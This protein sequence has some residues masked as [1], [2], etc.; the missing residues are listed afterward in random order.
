MQVVQSFKDVPHKHQLVMDLTTLHNQIRSFSSLFEHYYEDPF[1]V[2]TNGEISSS[3]IPTSTNCVISFVG[4]NVTIHDK[5]LIC[6]FV[7]I[8]RERLRAKWHCNQCRVH[9]YIPWLKT[10]LVIFL[11]LHKLLCNMV[12]S[13]EGV[14]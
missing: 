4:P 7:E 3:F 1:L 6:A 14:A 8:V 12:C 9:W 11:Q 5:G 10:L 2:N 13:H